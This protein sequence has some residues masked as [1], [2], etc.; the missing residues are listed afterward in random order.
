MRQGQT[1]TARV[2]PLAGDPDL[3]VWA[4]DHEMR[5]PWVSNGTGGN[6]E[7]SFVAPVDGTYQ[8]EVY[9]YTAAKYRLIVDVTET[10]VIVAG[11]S[12]VNQEKGQPAQPVVPVSSLP[13]A[14]YALVSPGATGGAVDYRLHLPLVRR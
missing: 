3:Y 11:A 2:E 8:V 6:D 14:Q 4:P 5:P 1:L 9:G 12:Y 13:G 7:V 10:G